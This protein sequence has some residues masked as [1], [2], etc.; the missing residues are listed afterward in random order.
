MALCREIT[1]HFISKNLYFY[2]INICI[3]GFILHFFECYFAW[4]AK[5]GTHQ[6]QEQKQQQ[7]QQKIF[8][9]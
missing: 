7:Q 6:K 1:V 9:R 3:E 8:D 5:K 2:Y 4:L